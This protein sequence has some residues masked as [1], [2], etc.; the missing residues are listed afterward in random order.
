MRLVVLLASTSLLAACGGGGPQTISSAPPPVSGGG[1][2]GTNTVHSFANP[3][4]P[5]TYK[6]VGSNHVY[7]YSQ[8]KDQ[9]CSQQ[10]QIY[11]GNASTVR[12]SS[13]EI[14][15]NP[16]DAIFTLSVAD[17]LTGATAQTRFQDPASRTD[18]DGIREPQWGTPELSNQNIN[19]LQA[20]DGDPRSPYRISGSGTVYT[21]DNDTAPSG[22]EGST[23]QAVSFFFLKPGTETQYVTYAG[24]A[25]N[26]FAFKS[27]PFD[28]EGEL[29]ADS[30]HVERGAFAFGE[31]TGNSAVPTTGSG[32]YQGSMLG[33][34]I[35]NP[36]LDGQD[37]I[38][39]NLPSYFQ[40]I[41]GS[42][43]L[44]VNFS[45]NTFSLALDGTVHAPQ[46]YTSDIPPSPASV[47]SEG[48]A[49][50]AA[51]KG[52]INLVNFGGFKGF[53]ESAGF[54]N[55]NGSKR[56]VSIAGSSI[57]GAFYG[58]NGEEAGGGFRIV[59][60]NPDERIDILGAFV[61]KK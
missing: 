47:I 46:I 57:D 12:D 3:T 16:R 6:G 13:I 56:D 35:F 51:G 37:S 50:A 38:A 52:D 28:E 24:Y 14:S 32:T 15:Y 48:A 53:F 19:Y 5:K 20:G 1:G 41:E 29:L 11:S 9:C 58:P 59:G 33:S 30:I 34:M 60:G 45:T 36:T 54:T 31:V 42:A 44:A 40:W 2:N 21:G 23:Y 17:A 7:E 8:L 49:F 18:F 4:E 55:P 10:Q 26:S 25:R 27:I 39:F 22:D 43:N 61:G